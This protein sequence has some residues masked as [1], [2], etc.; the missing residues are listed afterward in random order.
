MRQR[1]AHYVRI[2]LVFDKKCTQRIAVLHA[3]NCL[4][5]QNFY[6]EWDGEKGPEEFHIKG[7]APVRRHR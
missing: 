6:T 1:R 7:V 4:N 3:R 5:T 2:R